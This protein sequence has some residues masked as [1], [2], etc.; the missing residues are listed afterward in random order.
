MAGKTDKFH[1]RVAES[2]IGT[3]RKPWKGRIKVALVYPNT[4]HVGMS[5]LGFQTVYDLLN[6]IEHVVCERGFL[7]T[8]KR[9]GA[10]R[11]TTIESGSPISAFDVIAFSV[12]FEMIFP[13]FLTIL[14]KAGLPL[15][16][17]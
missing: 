16:I 6:K 5:N 8:D 11:I 3:I 15:P 7:P 17:R 9:P 10:G 13:T 14:E 12:S 4:Y 1:K 2:E